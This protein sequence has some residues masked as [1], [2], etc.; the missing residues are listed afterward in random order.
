MAGGDSGDDANGD[1]EDCGVCSGC[2]TNKR[3]MKTEME[4]ERERKIS[5]D[6]SENMGAMSRDQR[7][8][9]PA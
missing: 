4:R 5:G 9:K 8:I 3:M 1:G 2:N 7:L 6:E